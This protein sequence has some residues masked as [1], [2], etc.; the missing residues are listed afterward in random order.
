VRPQ[1][2][3]EKGIPPY[4]MAFAVMIA[5]LLLPALLGG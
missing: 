5:L 4:V 2:M 3:N 1:Y